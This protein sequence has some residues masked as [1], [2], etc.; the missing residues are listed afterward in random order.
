MGLFITFEGGEGCGKST[1]SRLLLKKLE[2]QNISV[3][4]THEPGGTS[5]GGEIRKLLKEKQ[6]SS[7]SPQAELFLFVAS[8]VQLLIELIRPALEETKVVI[9]DRFAD[10]TLVYQGYGRGL[11][12][13]TVEKVN[14]MATENIKPD[15]TILLDMSPEQGLARKRSLKDRFELEDLSFHHRVREGYLKMA[16][17]EPDRWLVIDASLPKGKIAEII[18]DRVSKLLLTTRTTQT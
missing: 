9:C 13:T 7:I 11:D 4:L 15:L 10:S 6:C 16:A 3:V 14:N 17:T 1:Q 18:W 8:R 2:Q 5:L 12:L